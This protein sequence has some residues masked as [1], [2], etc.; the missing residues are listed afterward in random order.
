MSDLRLCLLGAGRWGKR[1]IDTIKA[2]PGITLAALASRNP[3]SAAPADCEIFPD[4]RSAVAAPGI[5]GVIIA[6]PPELHREMA[7]AALD[8]DIPVLIEK[9]LTLSHAE[10][11]EIKDRAFERGVMVMVS[12]IHL[13]NT[14][15]QEMK[16]HLPAIGAITAIRSVAGNWG[17][18]RPD[19]PPLWDWAPHDLSMCLDLMGSLPDTVTATRL[20]EKRVEDG[21]GGNYRIALGFGF[22]DA[23]IEIGNMMTTKSRRLEISGDHGTLVLDDVAATLILDRAGTAEALPVPL[24]RPL[25]RQLAVF[26][27]ALRC[28]AAS[29]AMARRLSITH[30]FKTFIL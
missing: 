9:P 25:D 22:V 10:A 11:R 24:G 19:T 30:W 16:R 28:H 6:T 13:H 20:A 4:W 8:R 23:Q 18:F 17:P 15:Y 1:Y 7:V 12:N 27:D 14:A 29:G 21:Y 3:Q 5:D 2:Q 26:C